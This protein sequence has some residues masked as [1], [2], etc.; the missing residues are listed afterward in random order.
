[1]TKLST[2]RLNLCYSVSKTNGVCTREIWLLPAWCLYPVPTVCRVPFAESWYN[3]SM[4]KQYARDFIGM[5]LKTVDTIGNCQ[6]PVFS[7]GVAQ[8]NKI[9]NLWTFELTRS[10]K[11]RDN[12]EKKTTLSHGVVRFW[13]D[14]ETSNSK[15]EVSKS[16]SLRI[17]FSKTT[18][19]QRELFL[20]M[21]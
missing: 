3:Q 20:T 1:M 4:N 7:L 17:T 10:S 8:H 12:N 19:R 13:L 9:T 11:L 15:F 2:S 18:L 14:F 16:N 5:A 6:T 21:F